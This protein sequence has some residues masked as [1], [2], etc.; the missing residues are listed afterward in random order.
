MFLNKFLEVRN[1]TFEKLYK[2][3]SM[4]IFS[5]SSVAYLKDLF[6]LITRFDYQPYFQGVINIYWFPMLI[7]HM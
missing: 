7:V 2:A 1:T 3:L 4:N 5:S 6:L